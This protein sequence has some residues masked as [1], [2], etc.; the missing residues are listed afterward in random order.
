MLVGKALYFG[1]I[2]FNDSKWRFLVFQSIQG[3]CKFNYDNPMMIGLIKGEM[4]LKP[5]LLMCDPIV[6]INVLVSCVISP[7]E[8]FRLSIILITTNVVFSTNTKSCCHIK[9]LLMKHVDAPK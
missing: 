3:L 6:I 7:E 8:R 5:I 1:A 9:P 2:S 4:T